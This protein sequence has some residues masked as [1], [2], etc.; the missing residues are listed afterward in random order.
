MGSWYRFPPI[1]W[2]VCALLVAFFAVQKLDFMESHLF[3]LG[4]DSCA[5]GVRSESSYLL[6]SFESYSVFFKEVS[7]FQILNKVY[8]TFFL[9][10]RKDTDLISF[11]CE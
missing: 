8:D 7:M 10:K 3:I 6:Q 4:A 9:Y 2:A 11:S 5:V 1:L